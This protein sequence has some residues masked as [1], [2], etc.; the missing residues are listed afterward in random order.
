MTERQ[1]NTSSTSK[2]KTFF[3]RIIEARQRQADRYIAE[4][5]FDF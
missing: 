5:R 4:R 1:N 3:Q 2:P